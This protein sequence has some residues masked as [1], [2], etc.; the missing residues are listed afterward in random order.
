MNLICMEYFAKVAEEKSVLKAAEAFRVVPA[1]I[2]KQIKALEDNLETVLFYRTSNT[3]ILTENGQI[4]YRYI[5]QILSLIQSAINEIKDHNHALQTINLYVET[6]P[7]TFP[8]LIKGFKSLYPEVS[9]NLIQNFVKP[10]QKETS[11]DLLL[12]ASDHLLNS[13]N[14]ITLFKEECLI[15]VSTKNPLAQKKEVHLDDIRNVPFIQ[16]SSLSV[17]LN[18]IIKR[19][20]DAVNFTPISYD[21]CDNSFILNEM[22]AQDIGVA[23]LPQ[24]T[25]L[26]SDNPNIVLIRVPELNIIRY[27]N[28]SWN[29]SLYLSQNAR[30]F[31]AYAQEYFSSLQEALASND[32]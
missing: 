14:N 31:I 20:C 15:G 7:L 3:M 25:W 12:Y 21:Y 32:K 1:T 22:I 10:E 23:F 29:N 11:C 13:A 6:C 2:N 8:K 4:V 17:E 27:I 19:S 28:I 16:R 18:K 5:S 24:L 9:W 30:A 26:H